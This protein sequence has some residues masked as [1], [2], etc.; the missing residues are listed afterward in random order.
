MVHSLLPYSSCARENPLQVATRIDLTSKG[1]ADPEGLPLLLKGCFCNEVASFL[2]AFSS[3]DGVYVTVASSLWCTVGR[4]IIP[5][6]E[7]FCFSGQPVV[8]GTDTC[9]TRLFPWL[10]AKQQR[11][12]LLISG[13]FLFP[14]LILRS[15]MPILSAPE[16]WHSWI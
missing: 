10:N 14:K 3:F 4:I 8:K 11:P 1:S 13:L 7:S 9:K 16:Y 15:T 5:W 6:E 12:S 2:P